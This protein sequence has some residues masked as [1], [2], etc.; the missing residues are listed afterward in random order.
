MA[1]YGFRSPPLSV[2]PGREDLPHGGG[3]KR[4]QFL[5]LALSSARRVELLLTSSI[6]LVTV[7][8]RTVLASLK[9]T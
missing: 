3:E 8:P 6:L 4:V 5:G 2:Q 1:S 7:R 9:P